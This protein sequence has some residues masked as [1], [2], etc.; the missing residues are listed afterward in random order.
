MACINNWQCIILN[1]R[2][3]FTYGWIL[4]INF[5]WLVSTLIPSNHVLLNYE[6]DPTY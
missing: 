4:P 2:A 1:Q 6:S 3:K 5:N